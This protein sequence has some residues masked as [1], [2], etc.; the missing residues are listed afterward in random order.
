MSYES[1]D[2]RRVFYCG[3]VGEPKEKEKTNESKFLHNIQCNEIRK[4]KFRN[5]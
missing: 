5:S 1:G 2:D 3:H 4:K